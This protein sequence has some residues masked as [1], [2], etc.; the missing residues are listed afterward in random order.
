MACYGISSWIT[1]G[2][3]PEA[4]IEALAG[5]GFRRVELSD[6]ASPLGRA[7]E[8]DAAGVSE[9]L[10][11]A[12][13]TITS[14]HTPV[15][16]RFLD[17]AA[18]A[19]RQ[20]SVQANLDYFALMAAAG[21]PE[22]VIHPISSADGLEGAALAAAQG[23]VRDSL[24]TLAD[25][26][27][28]RG[29]RLAVENLGANYSLAGSMESVVELTEGL[30]EHVGLCHDLG[31]TV[32]AGLCP[33]HQVG[34]SLRSGRLFSLHVHDVNADLHDHFI[35]GEGCVD[36][37]AYLAELS[38]GGFAGIRTLEIAPTPTGFAE[39]LARAARVRDAW[40]ALE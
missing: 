29:L 26:A 17:V 36:F 8:A 24:Q 32:Q 20:Q 39:R 33:V 31:H 34:V 7:W 1:A 21:V 27:G 25:V 30:G 11:A 10:R 2:L 23:R 28:A 40:G 18:D 16:G 14:I 35:P 12:G 9:R 3:E 19:A 38:R 37:P 4:A 5:A 22:M 6:D 15:P 13:L